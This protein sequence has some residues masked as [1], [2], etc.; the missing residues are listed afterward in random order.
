MMEKRDGPLRTVHIKKN[1]A[2]PRE[3]GTFSLSKQPYPK[4]EHNHELKK[5]MSHHLS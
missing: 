2:Y 5:H 1:Q 4:K 3:I